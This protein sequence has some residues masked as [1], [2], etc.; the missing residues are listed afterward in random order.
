MT[1]TLARRKMGSDNNLT[2]K[3]PLYTRLWMG[4]PGTCWPRTTDLHRK[5]IA[6]VAD[7]FF[8]SVPRSSSEPEALTGA[9][10]HARRPRCTQAEPQHRHSQARSR[11]EQSPCHSARHS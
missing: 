6:A 3:F 5:N 2:M 9:F 1:D 4:S 7:V 11:A 8:G 10:I